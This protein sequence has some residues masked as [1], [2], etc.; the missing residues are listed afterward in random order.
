MQLELTVEQGDL[1]DALRRALS[2]TIP[3]HDVAGLIDEMGLLEI[4]IPEEYGGAG[5]GL[6]DV[7]VVMAELGRSLGRTPFFSSSVQSGWTLALAG[8]PEACSRYLPR[9]AAGSTRASLVTGPRFTDTGI[10]AV[11]TGDTLTLHGTQHAV[12]GAEDSDLLVVVAATEEGPELAVLAA[13]SA[14]VELHTRESLDLTRPLTTVVA[15]GAQAPAAGGPRITDGL[16]RALALSLTAL[17]AEEVGAARRCLELSVEHCSSRE[18]FGRVIGSFQAI[19]HRLVDMLVAV[20][21]AEAAVLDAANSDDLPTARFSVAAATAQVLASRAA[22][23]AAE[24]SIQVHGGVGFTWEHPL[25]H[26]FRRA[27]TDQLIL[28]DVPVHAETVAA[29]LVGTP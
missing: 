17:A 13:D 24:E 10:T 5:S 27:K 19:K 2:G 12:I 22:V 26:Y 18:Q 16:D 20:E 14:G 6:K 25:H 21:L 11:R 1:R 23:F 15:D 9:I 3:G 8:S 29:A 7:T 28:G 4:P